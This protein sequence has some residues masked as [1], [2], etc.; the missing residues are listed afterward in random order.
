M[1]VVVLA[2]LPMTPETRLLRLLGPAPMQIMALRELDT[3]P[4]SA[5]QRQP[6]IDILA[7]VRYLLDEAPD[8]SPEERT[9][10]TELRQRW[11]REKAELRAEGKAEA[12]LS[13]LVARGFQV[14]EGVRQRV[15]GC[16]DP[17]TLERWLARAITATTDVDV[18][19]A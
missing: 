14:S 13:V 9:V 1:W 5:A 2:E 17:N 11:E 4:L 7:D 6:W 15:L 18:V 19:A 12:I 16:K 8:L 3:L 10:M